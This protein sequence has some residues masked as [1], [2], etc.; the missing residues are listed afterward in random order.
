MTHRERH[1]GSPSST[2]DTERNLSVREAARR[3]FMES[4]ILVGQIYREYRE[5]GGR[6]ELDRLLRTRKNLPWYLQKAD[7]QR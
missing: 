2:A 4:R 5:S 7:T 6:T 3:D 1:W